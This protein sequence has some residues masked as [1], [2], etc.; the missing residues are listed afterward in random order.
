[1]RRVIVNV[2]AT[3]RGRHSGLRAS[4]EISKTVMRELASV[5]ILGEEFEYR[6]FDPW[7]EFMR[8]QFGHVASILREAA[9]DQ[10]AE[11]IKL[12]VPLLDAAESLD[13]FARLRLHLGSGEDLSGSAKL[14]VDKARALLERIAPD[15]ISYVSPKRLTEQLLIILRSALLTAGHQLRRSETERIYLDGGASV[16][17]CAIAA[18][19][20]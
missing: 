4:V 10:S 14:A 17:P 11:D 8:A 12:H 7:L 18:G 16:A 6:A 5:V 3:L 20:R 1:M 15:V 13:H 9:A 19:L 2:A